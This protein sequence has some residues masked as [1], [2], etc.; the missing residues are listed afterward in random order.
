MKVS[1]AGIVGGIVRHFGE[2][3]DPRSFTNR[4]HRLDD[5]LVISVLAVIAG[6]DGPMAIA[7]WAN[8]HEERLKLYLSLENGIPSH[9]TIARVLQA[10]KP[11][12][13]QQCFAAWVSS[14]IEASSTTETEEKID[15]PARQIAI[16][17]KCLRRS[18]KRCKDIGPLTLVNAWATKHGIALG[19]V[20]AE[21]KSN[22]ITAIPQLLAQLELKDAVVTMDAAGCQ[23][24]IADEIISGE[25]DYVLAL[26]GNQENLHC[27]VVQLFDKVLQEDTLPAA[28]SH[29][30]E[31][32]T[33]HGRIEQRDYYQMTMSSD[34]IEG[35][36]W[37]GLKTVGLAIRRCTEKGKE[38]IEKRYYI[39]SLPC[40]GEH[41]ADY[42]RSHWG[43]ENSLHWVLDMTFRED[44]NRTQ[45]RQLADNLGWLRRFALSLLKQHPGRQSIVMK[46]RCAGWSFDFLMEVLAGKA[47]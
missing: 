38:T 12:A 27:E 43:I 24:N 47:T 23:K 33:G 45:E 8:M 15:K 32:D 13:F 19:Q 16:D 37:T 39:S 10:L 26:K 17:G 41:F 9:D 20:A 4:L 11:A 36:K 5:V 28:V 44:E 35:Q 1:E 21:E 42:V 7:L 22:E 3:E 30:Q 29:Y 18:H 14:L 2:I 25:G 34:S 46:R 6:A 31:T 40:H